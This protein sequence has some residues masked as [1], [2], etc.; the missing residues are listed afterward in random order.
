[1]AVEKYEGGFLLSEVPL[2]D[3]FLDLK[4]MVVVLRQKNPDMAFDLETITRDPLQIP[5][6]TDK[7]WATFD[8]TYS[9]YPARD[10]AK[11]L[12]FVSA[13]PPKKPL[14]RTSGLS[15]KQ[16]LDLEDEDNLKSIIYARQHLEL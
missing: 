9:P 13:H 4:Q 12:E 16:Q 8:D 3:G 7:Y 5:V 15:P 11:M 1:M 2:G 6:F 10:L 14:P